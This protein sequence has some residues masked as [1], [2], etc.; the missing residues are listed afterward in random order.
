MPVFVAGLFYTLI[1]YGEYLKLVTLSKAGIG[2]LVNILEVW[3]GPSLLIFLY[4]LVL[5]GLGVLDGGDGHFLIAITPWCG[6]YRMKN[7]VLY[8]YPL[9]FVYLVLYLLYKYKFN[10]KGICKDQLHDTILLLKSIPQV[11]K[12]IKNKEPYALCE[13]ISYRTG[14]LDKPAGMIPIYAAV[15]LSFI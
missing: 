15:L 5:F 14:T 1:P 11:W 2:L 10:V 4:S 7:I 12:N 13:G 3:L 8:F 9:A 6:L